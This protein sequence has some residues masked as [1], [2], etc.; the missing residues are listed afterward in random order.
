MPDLLSTPAAARALGITERRLRYLSELMVPAP[1]R[2]GKNMVW[3]SADVERA[4]E[5][6]ARVMVRKR[7]P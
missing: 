4:R 6:H 3:S 5:L 2:V 1:A 7:G